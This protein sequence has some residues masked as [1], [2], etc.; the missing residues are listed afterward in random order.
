MASDTIV[1]GISPG[2]DA[3]RMRLAKLVD[4]WTVGVGPYKVQNN[5]PVISFDDVLHNVVDDDDD[6][7]FLSPEERQERHRLATLVDDWTPGGVGGDT[8]ETNVG[9]WE[10]FQRMVQ[11]EREDAAKR[12]KREMRFFG[13]P[14][15]RIIPHRGAALTIVP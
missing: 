13:C 14:C 11:W 8:V 12:K 7:P 15:F 6:E 9:A 1:T 4:E 10:R 3:E 2:E 5:G